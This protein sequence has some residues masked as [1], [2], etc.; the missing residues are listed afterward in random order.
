MNAYYILRGEEQ[1]GPY[2]MDQMRSMW[3][4]GLITSQTLYWCEGLPGWMMVG[5]LIANQPRIQR[6]ARM[7]SAQAES[8]AT[9]GRLQQTG[10]T[11][12]YCALGILLVFLAYQALRIYGISEQWPWALSA[13][14]LEISG[15]SLSL[16]TL[17]VFAFPFLGLYLIPSFLAVGKKLLIPVFAVNLL[18]G[19]TLIGWLVALGM[20][21][22]SSRDAEAGG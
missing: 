19:W 17:L 8:D 13:P 1:A 20:A 14:S 10:M 5:G 16:G 6:A 15:P 18:L 3:N 21:L 4:A 7:E 22:I 12:A 2:T 11:L 9:P